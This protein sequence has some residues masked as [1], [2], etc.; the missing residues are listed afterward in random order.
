MENHEI[1]NSN[2]SKRIDICNIPFK[3]YFVSNFLYVYLKILLFKLASW[4]TCNEA[5]VYVRPKI[6]Q[7]LWVEDMNS[8]NKN[9]ITKA[10]I[11]RTLSNTV[12]LHTLE[13]R[14]ASHSSKSKKATHLYWYLLRFHIFFL[15]IL[16]KNI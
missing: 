5:L 16:T 14:E 12:R 4:I 3:L 10:H 6:P 2:K 11:A 15:V 1:N 9:R 8:V 7:K 13:K